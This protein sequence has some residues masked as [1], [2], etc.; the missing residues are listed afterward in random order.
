M[1]GLRS[2]SA[3]DPGRDSSCTGCPSASSDL[4]GDSRLVERAAVGRPWRR[5]VGQLQRGDATVSPWPIARLTLS[6]AYQSPLGKAAGLSMCSCRRVSG[7]GMR[8][9]NSDRGASRRSWRPDRVRRPP[10]VWHRRSGRA[11]T[12]TQ[13]RGRRSRRHSTRPWH[14]AGSPGRMTRCRR[15]G[16]RISGLGTHEACRSPCPRP[17]FAR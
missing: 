3:D 11:G 5:H 14:G 9:R 12:R 4:G 7:S 10:A 6:P 1:A 17:S 2:T 8:P 16:R 13:H 15:F